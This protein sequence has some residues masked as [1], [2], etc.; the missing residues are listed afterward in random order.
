MN[1]EKNEARLGASYFAKDIDGDEWTIYWDDEGVWR[2]DVTMTTRNT[3]EV[4]QAFSV[5]DAKK[6]AQEFERNVKMTRLTA[7]QTL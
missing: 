3:I 5:E 6:I 4:G 7:P 2:V 1:F